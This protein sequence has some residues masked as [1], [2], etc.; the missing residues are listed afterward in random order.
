MSR[1]WSL[2]LAWSAGL[3]ILGF[4]SPS[5]ALSP[6]LSSGALSVRTS[7][8]LCPCALTD[9]SKG[10]CYDFVNEAERTCKSRT[11][12]N[13]YTCTNREKASHYCIERAQEVMRVTPVGAGRCSAVQETKHFRVPYGPFD[14]WDFAAQDHFDVQLDD[15]L[16]KLEPEICQ[17]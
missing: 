1:T 6:S 5:Q 17:L 12:E 2:C 7:P 4:I 11:C 14:N 9:D 10:T 16:K 3:L 13:S 15:D 8:V